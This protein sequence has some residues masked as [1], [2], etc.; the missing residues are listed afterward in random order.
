MQVSAMQL[1]DV[2]L[3]DAL[4]AATGFGLDSQAELAREFARIWLVRQRPPSSGIDAFLHVWIAADEL[5]VIAI[6][7]APSMRRRGLAEGLLR[8]LFTE[9]RTRGSRLI[10]LEVRRSNA[11]ALH[12]YRKFGFSI[13]RIRRNYYAHPDEDGV[14]MLLSFDNHG[15][16]VQLPD[17]FPW[18]EVTEC[19][20]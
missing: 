16:V 3:V 5:H 2:A 12:L 13:S 15:N 18:P 11:A 7:T 1:G 4:A 17:E 9:A 19:P 10:L 6:G 8:H 20:S 14:E